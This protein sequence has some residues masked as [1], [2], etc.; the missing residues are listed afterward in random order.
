MN[1]KILIGLVATIVWLLAIVAKHFW[2]DIDISG[3]VTACGSALSS[4][5]VWHVAT[6]DDSPD[7]P[8]IPATNAGSL[9]QPSKD[10]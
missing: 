6:K 4:V 8:T 10:A 5:G 7:V 2:P 1:T 9:S 3:L